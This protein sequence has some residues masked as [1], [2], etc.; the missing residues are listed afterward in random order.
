VGSCLFVNLKLSMRK[1]AKQIWVTEEEKEI[2]QK[3]QAQCDSQDIP[4]STAK[5]GWAKSSSGTIEWSNPAY[6]APEE[7]SYFDVRDEII[8]EMKKY[9]PTYPVIE[10]KPTGSGLLVLSLADF[11][12]NKLC[13]ESV[14]GT[15]YDI[16][17]A[18][19]R[20]YRGIEG[21]LSK[22]S[23]FP[24]DKVLLI[25][26][27]DILNSDTVTHTTTNGTPQHDDKHWT[28]GYQAAKRLVI[29]VIE[30]LL[31]VA[32]IHVI[33]CPSNHDYQSGY[34]LA[35]CIA[36]WFD[37]HPNITFDVSIRHRKYFQYGK[38][39]IMADHGD[40]HKATDAPLIMAED[41]PKMWGNTV[42]RYSYKHHVHHK[43]VRVYQ[44][45]KECVGVTVEHLGSP[46][47]ADEWHDKNGYLSK[48]KLEAFLHDPEWGRFGHFTH[49]L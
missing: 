14:S 12:I 11:H 5:R 18:E 31:E 32:D 43:D 4:I 13:E 37:S 9:A 39:M 22:V 10:R 2:F 8:E 49:N 47:P 36:C 48:P 38:N 27:N 6:K 42:W 34:F 7:V 24:V 41:M 30:R 28:T 46:A 25:I 15:S 26:G 44:K 33:H 35:D 17:K 40:G 19:L 3:I 45:V 20:V 29:A 21:L 1:R 23:G 16:E